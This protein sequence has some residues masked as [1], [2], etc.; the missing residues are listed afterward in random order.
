MTQPIG[1]DKVMRTWIATLVATCV[2]CI[3]IGPALAQG[4]SRSERWKQFMEKYDKNEDGKLDEKEREAVK[5]AFAENASEWRKKMGE[6]H[7]EMRKEFME[8][9]DKDKDG[10]L[11]D[12][13]RA[14]VRKDWEARVQEWRKRHQAAKGS[15]TKAKDATSP[16]DKQAAAKPKCCPK[17]GTCPKGKKPG[18]CPRTGTCPKAKKPGTCPKDDTCPKAKRPPHAGHRPHGHPH[19]RHSH[20][21]QRG[22]HERDR[23]P[24]HHR[25]H[26]HGDRDRKSHHE[27]PGDQD[28]DGHRGAPPRRGPQGE[29]RPNAGEMA[30]KIIVKQDKNKDGKLSVDEYSEQYRKDFGETDKNDDGWVDKVEL[31][32]RLE[33]VLAKMRDRR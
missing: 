27:R 30:A 4:P 17:A 33:Q 1:G 28:G 31:T 9:Y 32:K 16:S 7:A 21:A 14:A 12:E 29:G 19:H 2:V 5:M 3:A 26:G 8:K 13:E 20:H 22:H 24:G 18:T 10:K 25:H 15:E 23:H 6:R 11:S